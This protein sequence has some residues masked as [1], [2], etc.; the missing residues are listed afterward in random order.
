MASIVC[1]MRPL[2]A[3]AAYMYWRLTAANPV[4]LACNWDNCARLL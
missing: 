1:A 3:P 4:P 2:L